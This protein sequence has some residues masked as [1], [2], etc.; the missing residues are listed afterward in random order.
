MEK[1]TGSRLKKYTIMKLVK[2][3]SLV[4]LVGI[5]LFSIPKS[6]KGQLFW[7]GF[8]GGINM[9]WFTTPNID[10]QILSSGTGW[11]LGFFLKYGK[12]PFYQLEFRWLRGGN[13]IDVAVSDTIISGAVPFHQFSIPVKV[14]YPIVYKPMF[15]WNVSGGA[16]I[17]TTFLFSDNNFEFQRKDMRNP[18]IAV[19]AGTGIQF[20]NFILDVDYSY[21]LNDLFVGDQRD[22]GVNWGEHLQVITLKVG[23]VF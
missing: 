12:K 4:L 8:N 23:M 21:H 22:F 20:M 5:M 16:S 10:N 18:Q 2:K 19:I 9:N 7:L 15:K 3:Y 11:D 1:H 6:S 13:V 14:G 17:G